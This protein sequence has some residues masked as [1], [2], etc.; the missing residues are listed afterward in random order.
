MDSKLKYKILNKIVVIVLSFFVF[1]FSGCAYYNYLYNAKKSYLEGEMKRKESSGDQGIKKRQKV[2]Q[3]EYQKAIDSSGRMLELHPDSRWEDDALLLMAK[4]YYHIDQFRNAIKKIEELQGKYPNSELIPE[5]ILWKG[6]SFLKISQSDSAQIVFKEV[7]SLENVNDL[8]AQMYLSLGDS[9]YDEERWDSAIEEY[10][11]V[12][13]VGSEDEWVNSQALIKVG[14]SL[15]FQGKK[16]EALALYEEVLN[17]KQPR[18]LR[19]QTVLQ[20]SIVLRELGRSEEARKAFK[21]LQKDGAFLEEF[22][23]LELEIARCELKLEL[24]EDAK[25]RLE[26]LVERESKG[27]VNAGA[28]LELGG[29]YWN[30]DH[31]LKEAADSY[32]EAKKTGRN[33]PIEQASDSLLN[34]I[35]T[36]SEHW[37]ILKYCEIVNSKIDS[38]LA[39]LSDV[40]PLDTVFI[41][42]V[43]ILLKEEKKR[44]KSRRNSFSSRNDPMKMMVEEARKAQKEEEDSLALEKVET[45]SVFPLDSLNLTDF[46]VRTDSLK[47]N[48]W[49][50]LAGYY[51]FLPGYNDSSKYFFDLV[52]QQEGANNTWSRSK[53]SLAYIA[54]TQGDTSL[55]DTHLFNILEVSSDDE[56]SEM[57]RKTLNLDTTE[58]VDTLEVFLNEAEEFWFKEDDFLN[59]RDFY[60][61]IAAK[62][63]SA[64]DVRGR[65]LLAAAWLSLRKI[66]EDSIAVSIYNTIEEEFKNSDYSKKARS[67]RKR[68]KTDKEPESRGKDRQ[69]APIKDDRKNRYDEE[70]PFKEND[71][72]PN[73]MDQ[74]G[75]EDEQEVIVYNPDDV[76]DLPELLTPRAMLKSYT[77]MNYPFELFGQE[78]TGEIEIEIVIDSFGKIV[79][80]KILSVVPENQGFEEASMKVLDQL[81]YRAGRMRG[82]SVSVKIKQKLKFEAQ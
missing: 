20:H 29:I 63:D 65:S 21:K 9:Y 22:P 75:S 61:E 25:K 45:D 62:A 43:A 31:L 57:V 32:R 72:S 47:I 78:V 11:K 55:H 1:S 44:H 52:I 12:L 46:I 14:E 56:I 19:F 18:F 33:S 13:S 79:D 28:Y 39:G 53:A 77:S 73:Y 71:I 23:K 81:E 17:T 5:G 50:E 51:L 68:I 2:G 26:K 4:A 15:K 30:Q 59:T 37:Q 49:F 34:H 35:K 36:V 7:A 40:F 48:T 64:S 69:N 16:E 66:G 6:M 8:K 76:D 58:T 67:I 74:T 3:S 60:L 82:K 24:F 80:S 38:S 27:M 10:R 41:D 70:F 42:S 54:L